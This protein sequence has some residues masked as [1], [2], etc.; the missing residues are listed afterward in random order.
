MNFKLSVQFNTGQTQIWYPEDRIYI[1]WFRFAMYIHTFS[2]KPGPTCSVVFDGTGP[3]YGY[4]GHS[5]VAHISTRFRVCKMAGS[6]CDTSGRF[7]VAPCCYKEGLYL[8]L[9][10]VGC[11]SSYLSVRAAK[12]SSLA[13]LCFGDRTV[14]WCPDFHKA[15]TDRHT[16]L[17]KLEFRLT[18]ALCSALLCHQHQQR[19][20]EHSQQPH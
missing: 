19:R 9:C 3:L 13:F 15:R 17:V 11:L 20:L 16:C 4:L 12:H 8:S 5:W 7:L 6:S 18:S 2:D 1:Q 14:S 10:D